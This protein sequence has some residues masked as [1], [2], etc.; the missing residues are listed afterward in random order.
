MTWSDLLSIFGDLAFSIHA[1]CKRLKLECWIISVT[2][3]ESLMKASSMFSCW[4]NFVV[5]GVNVGNS[6]AMDCG[7]T[8]S[9]LVSFLNNPTV[10]YAHVQTEKQTFNS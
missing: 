1:L 4:E 8:N 5:T 10:Y 2:A 6:W 9:G 7:F 3:A